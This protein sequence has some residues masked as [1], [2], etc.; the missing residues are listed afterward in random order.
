MIALTIFS[1]ILSLFIGNY[2]LADFA[3]SHGKVLSDE[4]INISV[5]PDIL[6]QGNASLRS[7]L[8]EPDEDPI[9]PPPP[10]GG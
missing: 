3:P 10:S 8:P 1:I 9:P 5:P 2:F 4:E 6:K 7:G